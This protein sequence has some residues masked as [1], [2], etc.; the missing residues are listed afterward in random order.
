[1][2]GLVLFEGASVLDGSPI[3]AIATLSS[4]NKKT[5]DMVQTWIMR[6]DCNPVEASKAN[7]DSSI[8]GSCPHR[9]NKGGACYV[10]L[11]Q[12]PLSVYKSYKKGLYAK[13]SPNN[14]HKLQGRKVRLGSYGDPAA[15]PVSV[16]DAVNALADN[17][18]GYTH[19]LGHKNFDARILDYCMASADTA[20]Q[21]E[22]YNAMGI[23]TFRVKSENSPIGDNE[24]ECLSDSQN[25]TCEQCML[26]N[27]LKNKNNPS[28]VINVHGTR[29]N[30]YEN[31]F[32]K[33]V[34]KQK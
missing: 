33:I 3:V 9:Q 11:G 1:M 23:R 17:V 16:W 13:L 10:N 30:K 15:I 18:T 32:G 2:R 4:A 19:Q 24:I 14:M 21:A 31:K 7:L 27:G 25:L 26:C 22:K 20:R 12:A 6:S 8:C 28:V 34:V 29:K 5:G